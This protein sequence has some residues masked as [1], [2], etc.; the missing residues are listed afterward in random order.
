[1]AG[2]PLHGI[3]QACGGPVCALVKTLMPTHSCDTPADEGAEP[4]A[5]ADLYADLFKSATGRLGWTP[6]DVW[7]ATLPE[8]FLAL[9]GHA[10]WMNVL[11]GSA[12][13]DQDG[14]SDEQRKQNEA[15]GL[16]PEFDRSGLMALR[17]LSG[18]R[19][20]MTA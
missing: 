16:D 5:W 12:G 4:I 2:S 19:V 14:P 9:E 18:M 1:M 17:E 7:N 10:D 20:G 13:E 6:Q 11:H 3:Q 8:I 15:Q